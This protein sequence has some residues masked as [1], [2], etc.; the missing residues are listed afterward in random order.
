MR[1]YIV[2]GIFIM[3]V[4]TT[5]PLVSSMEKNTGVSIKEADVLIHQ[6][7]GANNP[8]IVDLIAGGGSEESAF[9]V[10]YVHAW[11]D[12]GILYVKYIIDSED[13]MDWYLT[14]THVHIGFDLND[15]PL[16]KK[17]S[18]KIG[19]FAYSSSHDSLLEYTYEISYNGES[20]IAAHAVVETMEQFGG[21]EGFELAL[22][23]MAVMIV[24]PP[25]GGGPA[26]FPNV[27]ITGDPLT[28]DYLGWCADTDYGI[29]PGQP[30]NVYVYSSYEPLPN[31]TIEYPE[32]LDLVNWILNQNYVGQTSPGGYGIY[33]YGD[34]QK[35]IWTLVDDDPNSGGLGPWSQNRT[36]EI[37][38]AAY[39]N[40]EGFVPDCDDTIAVILVPW[41]RQIIIAQVTLID[42]EV[43]CY[44]T[45]QG[46]TAWG[47]GTVFNTKR[48]WSMYFEYTGTY[49][50]NLFNN[51]EGR[52]FR[53]IE[54]L[55]L[56]IAEILEQFRMG[57]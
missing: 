18:P 40:G 29:N 56:R 45:Y 54:L 37:L 6:F 39:A 46:E 1:K 31:G 48:D 41:Y 12:N 20:L 36:D 32:N 43:P 28:G 47:N 38:A 27:N 49:N 26:Y 57:R 42:V 13:G 23:E 33:T 21:L 52:T 4:L 5:M 8:M 7:S 9:R 2:L 15:F 55:L 10:G 3:L 25:V 50:N 16:T 44:G 24:S 17:G 19:K 53:I 22:P 30:L 34:V 51:N 11:D 35:A 14:E